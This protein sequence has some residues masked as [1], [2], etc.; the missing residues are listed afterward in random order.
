MC[1]NTQQIAGENDIEI[2][3][4]RIPRS[5]RKD[6]C[7]QEII[8]STGKI[9]GLIHIFLQWSNVMSTKYGIVKLPLRHP[10]NLF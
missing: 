4:I 9:E 3:F 7:F 10:L 8:R 2:K 6:D 1:H 5:F